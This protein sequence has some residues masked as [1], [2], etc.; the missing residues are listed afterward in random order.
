[1]RWRQQ[2]RI[3]P[4]SHFRG[5]GEES[6]GLLFELFICMNKRARV[7]LKEDGQLPLLETRSLLAIT[8][9]GRRGPSADAH[10]L[11]QVNER[12]KKAGHR[13]IACTCT[14]RSRGI[15]QCCCLIAV[16]F[17]FTE[18]EKKKK[19][20]AEA[21]EKVNPRHLAS[22]LVWPKLINYHQI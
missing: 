14:R 18:F 5:G 15:F 11:L 17:S 1:M 10:F 19:K 12:E 7:C 9:A 16:K 6:S 2:P 20:K 4:S 21:L 3:L 22:H 8:A 13:I